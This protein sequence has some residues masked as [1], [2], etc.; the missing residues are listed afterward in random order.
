MDK[1]MVILEEYKN[2]AHD[3]TLVVPP[4]RPKYMEEFGSWMLVKK[5]PRRKSTRPEPIG[6]NEN[7]GGSK[8]GPTWAAGYVRNQT[9]PIGDQEGNFTY[10]GNLI[11]E[12]HATNHVS[13]PGGSRFA[14]LGEDMGDID[15]KLNSDP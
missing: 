1:L 11:G 15:I 6:H 8:T 4:L 3:P 7:T 12:N 9:W 2:K 10:E 5:P 14:I 13:N